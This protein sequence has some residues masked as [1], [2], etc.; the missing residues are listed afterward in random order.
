MNKKILRTER[1]SYLEDYLNKL[2]EA[3]SPAGSH[4]PR[5]YPK[6]QKEDK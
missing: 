5:L 1:H 3:Q 4:P 6:S 2:R